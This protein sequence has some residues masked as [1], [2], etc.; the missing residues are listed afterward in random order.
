MRVNKQSR[1]EALEVE[2]ASWSDSLRRFFEIGASADIPL[3]RL[4]NTMKELAPHL[5]EFI[6]L[7]IRKPKHL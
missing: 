2:S 6:L 5:K 1:V 7:D 3:D 4:K